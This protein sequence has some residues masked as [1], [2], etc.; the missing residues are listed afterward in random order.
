MEEDE[1]SLGSRVHSSSVSQISSVG[2]NNLKKQNTNTSVSTVTSSTSIKPNALTRLFTRNK[3][4]STL[5]ESIF[6][7]DDTEKPVIE[8]KP[9]NV[10]R[11]TKINKRRGKNAKDLTVQTEGLGVQP[12]PPLTRKTSVSSPVSTLHSLFHRSSTSANF[13]SSAIDSIDEQYP[14]S[15][16]NLSSNNSNSAINDAHFAQVYKFTDSNYLVDEDN[17]D[18]ELFKK[19]FQQPGQPTKPKFPNS[20]IS[21]ASDDDNEEIKFWNTLLVLVKP[22]IL[23][24]QQKVLSN[25]LKGP[26]LIMTEE[27]ISTFIRDNFD[28][29]LSLTDEELNDIKSREITQNL[30]NFFN[31]LIILFN[32]DFKVTYLEDLEPFC[33]LWVKLHDQWV[34]FRDRIMYFILNSFTSLSEN[35]FIYKQQ[36]D[37]ESLLLNSFKDIIV[38]PFIELRNKS[39]SKDKYFLQ[40]YLEGKLLNDVVQ[41]FG[42][43]NTFQVYDDMNPKN[44]EFLN[45]FLW[46][47][48]L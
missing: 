46:L 37:I 10:F 48:D 30:T 19:V 4:S 16:I 2:F 47:S 13:P 26:Q 29:S 34:F 40:S 28:I 17:D 22:V 44:H 7:E 38:T 20:P 36:I 45:L 42:L 15:T 32:K 11:L 18:S 27:D 21:I 23:S 31:K 33:K 35:S 25:G 3:S 24:S 43:I 41:C 1:S 6:P 14:R 8:K 5:D 9:S 12:P 39:Y